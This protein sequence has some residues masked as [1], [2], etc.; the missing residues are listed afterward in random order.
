MP[1]AIE[2]RGRKGG[3]AAGRFAIPYRLTARPFAALTE[4]R[5]P[6]SAGGRHH[7]NCHVARAACGS[8]AIE[9]AARHGVAPPRIPF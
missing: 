5:C 7:E 8:Y 2:A 1:R 6:P 3:K 4:S 9:I